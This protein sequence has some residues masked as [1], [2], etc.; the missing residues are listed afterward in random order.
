MQTN[1]RHYLYYQIKH[2]IENN[3]NRS[4]YF[5]HLWEIFASFILFIRLS[6]GIISYL[7]HCKIQYWL[8]DPITY[9]FHISFQNAFIYYSFIGMMPGTLVMVG[10]ILVF[11]HSANGLTFQFF[12]EL[13]VINK[14]QLK[15]CFICE[16]QRQTMLI[17]Q[18]KKNLIQL[19]NWKWKFCWKIS[20]IK[21]ILTK[22]CW[23]LTRI[24]FNLSGQNIDPTLIVQ[25]ELKTVPGITNQFRLNLFNLVEYVDLFF[26][27]VHLLTGTIFMD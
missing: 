23:L 10:T 22:F 20:L 24:Q 19:N 14:D 5:K 27:I 18:F 4:Y 15:K 6:L 26:Y 3:Q 17:N 13:I 21:I 1:V 2:L 12:Y 7:Y 8:L 11:F 25:Y 16:K 9:F